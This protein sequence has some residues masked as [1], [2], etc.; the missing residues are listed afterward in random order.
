MAK[1]AEPVEPFEP[2]ALP[3]KGTQSKASDVSRRQLPDVVLTSRQL[4]VLRLMRDSDEELVYSKGVGY[5]GLKR[6][7]PRTI[8]AL[9]RAV[10]IKLDQYSTVGGCERYTI[11][12]TGLTLLNGGGIRPQSSIRANLNDSAKESQGEGI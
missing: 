11:N 2:S 6:V 3:C 10:V 9:L 1:S 4:K 5:V 12:E 8:F 7:S